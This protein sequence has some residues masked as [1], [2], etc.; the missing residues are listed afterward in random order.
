MICM[1][2]SSTADTAATPKGADTQGN[3]S[4]IGKMGGGKTDRKKTWKKQTQQL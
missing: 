1:R 2:L 4:K 3:R